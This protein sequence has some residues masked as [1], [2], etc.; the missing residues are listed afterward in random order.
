MSTDPKIQATLAFVFDKKLSQ[1][2]LIKKE[3]PVAHAGLLNGLGGKL[4]TGESH[5]ECVM[6]EVEEEAGL[7]ITADAWQRVG[8]MYWENWNVSIWTSVIDKPKNHFFPDPNVDWCSAS[9]VP[10]NSIENLEWLIPL[11]VDVNKKIID[12]LKN[13]PKV[14]IHYK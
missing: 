14:T 5:L 13:V 3:K 2:L 10:K 9:P 1:V 8:D 7:K 4:E 11:S 12:K 6:R